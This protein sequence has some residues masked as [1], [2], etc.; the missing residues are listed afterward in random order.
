M[1]PG[2]AKDAPEKISRFA[3]YPVLTLSSV[4][5]RQTPS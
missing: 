1:T 4:L 3:M 2:A 5:L